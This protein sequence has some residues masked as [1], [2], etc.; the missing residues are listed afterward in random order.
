MGPHS[1]LVL[2]SSSIYRAELLSRLG[3]PFQAAAPE[4][5]E[6]QQPNESA[7]E[8]VTRLA[9]EKALAVAARFTNHLIIGSDQIAT[10]KSGELV[11]KPLTFENAISQLQKFS[12]ESAVFLTSL[13]LY[14]SATKALQ[15]TTETTKVSFRELSKAQI[16]H[17]ITK[18]NPLNCAGSFKCESLGISLFKSIEGNDPNSLI[19]LPLIALTHFLQQEGVDP[20]TWPAST[21]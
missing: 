14:N 13:C 21:T 18:D 19:G 10:S 1:N 6:E 7:A 8:L 11:T 12:G 15:I 3:I 20:L 5:D 4:I 9:Q 16:Q 2:A 17:Y